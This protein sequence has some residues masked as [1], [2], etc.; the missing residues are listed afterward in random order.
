MWYLEKISLK[1]SWILCKKKILHYT[2][3]NKLYYFNKMSYEFYE[4]IINIKLF[5]IYLL[6]MNEKIMFQKWIKIN[7]KY[8]ITITLKKVYLLKNDQLF[9]IFS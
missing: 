8:T 7:I 6:K 5:V 9:L 2:V 4:S 3:N 1:N